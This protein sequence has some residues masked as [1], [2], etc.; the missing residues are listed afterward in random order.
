MGMEI[1]KV[2][3]SFVFNGDLELDGQF[4]WQDEEQ[5]PAYQ[6]LNVQ[7]DWSDWLID[8]QDEESYKG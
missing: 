2:M 1:F 4:L 3:L 7:D 8:E 5:D 6:N